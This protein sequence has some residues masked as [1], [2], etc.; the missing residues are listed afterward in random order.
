MSNIIDEIKAEMKKSISLSTWIPQ[1]IKDILIKKNDKL[2]LYI[3]YPKLYDN[4]T[5][6]IEVYKEVGIN[7]RDV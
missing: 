5:A 6:L 3:G 1:E 7:L 2:L 4:Q